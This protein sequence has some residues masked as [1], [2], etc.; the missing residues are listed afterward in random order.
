MLAVAPTRLSK[1]DQLRR[2]SDSSLNLGTVIRT[3][4]SSTKMAAIVK[5]V[6]TQTQNFS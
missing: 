4:M 2:G 1:V 5:L 6:A 3:K